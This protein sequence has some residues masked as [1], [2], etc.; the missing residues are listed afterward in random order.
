MMN[1]LTSLI[2]RFGSLQTQDALGKR[3]A[4][5]LSR[6]N[7]VSAPREV[8]LVYYAFVLYPP[9]TCV[10]HLPRLRWFATHAVE[11]HGHPAIATVEQQAIRPSTKR[12][13]DFTARRIV[14]RPLEQTPTA[15]QVGVAEGRNHRGY[16][17]II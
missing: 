7:P 8:Q 6:A 15:E 5:T 14:E 10:A 2:I 1:A 16:G 9:A 12:P 17:I 13:A 4:P 11:K 3:D